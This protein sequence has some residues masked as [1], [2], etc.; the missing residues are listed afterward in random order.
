M[1]NG[2]GRNNRRSPNV[3]RGRARTQRGARR[4]QRRNGGMN[5]SSRVRNGRG[6]GSMGP[7][8]NGREFII[9][10]GSGTSKVWWACPK[11]SITADCRNVT[12]QVN[13]NN[14]MNSTNKSG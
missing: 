12:D 9:A 8:G 13:M 1:A 5:V 10:N 6:Y 14:Y 11:P 4:M 3:R 2:Y 7:H